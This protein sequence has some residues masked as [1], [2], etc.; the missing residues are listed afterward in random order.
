MH[1]VLERALEFFDEQLRADEVQRGGVDQRTRE[2]LHHSTWLRAPD[3][4]VQPCLDARLREGAWLSHS[5]R[6]EE[7]HESQLVGRIQEIGAQE[8]DRVRRK[9]AQLSLLQHEG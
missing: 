2:R 7:A 9:G 6:D 5:E 8:P 3:L 4:E 1:G